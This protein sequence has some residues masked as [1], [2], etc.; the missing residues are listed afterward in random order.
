MDR[1]PALS[2]ATGA[3]IYVDEIRESFSLLDIVY[4]NQFDGV[5]ITE[6]T[7]EQTEENFYR[8]APPDWLNFHI[9]EVAKSNGAGSPFIKRDGY[10]RL[11]QQIRKRRRGPGTSAIKLYHHE[12]S[13]GTTLAMHVLWKLRKTFRC[14]VLTDSTPDIM[15]VTK[16][17]V[18]LFRAGNQDSLNTVL[19]LLDDTFNLDQ[20][21]DSIMEEIVEQEIDV[22]VPV[23]ILLSCVRTDH[24]ARETE[25]FCR[26]KEELKRN[27]RKDVIL[28]NNI[29]DTEKKL[30]DEK[31]EELSRKYGD[32]TKQFHGFNILQTNFSQDYIQEACAMFAK[33]GRKN[34]P[35]KTQL[36][37]FLSLLNAYV[38][39]SYLL[40]SHCLDFLIHDHPSHDEQLLL[41]QMQPFS[42]LI[43]TLQRGKRGQRK[44]RMAHPA[45]AKCCTE[46]LAEAGVCRSDTA[47]NFLSS[48][49]GDD[50]PACLFGFIKHM[51]TKREI[52]TNKGTE[53]AEV[54]DR[55]PR[56]ENDR[57]EKYSTL[58][59]HITQ[60]E[61]KRES[62]SVLKVASIQ[63]DEN[64]LFPQALAR[65]C[66][67]E[68]KD[69]QEAEIWAKR[70]KEREPKKSFIADTLG[71]VHKNHLKNRERPAEA[72]EILQLARKAIE[73]F[74]EEEQLAGKEHGKNIENGKTKSLHDFNIRGHFGFLQVC[75]ILFD[76]LVR[77]DEAWRGVLTSN[78]S[79]GSVLQTLGDNKLSRFNNLINSLREKVE[80]KFEFL[81]AFLT[82]SESAMK[83]DKAYVTKEAAECYKKYVGVSVP[84]H[85]G[86]LQQTLQ[87]LKQ[88][89]AVTSAGVLS[90]L[91]RRCTTSDVKD[92]AAWWE[93]ICHSEDFTTRAFVN[94]IFAKIMLK[95]ANQPLRSSDDQ[96]AF[97]QKKLSDMQAE[98]HMMALLLFWPTDDEGQPVSDLRQLIE[99][100]KHSY[101]QEYKTMFRWR[102][103]RPLFFIGPGKELRRFVH[104]RVLEI[105][106]TQ[107]ALQESNVY[108]RNESI[109]KDPTVQDHLLK[110]EGVVRNYRLYA[111]F[112]ST[113]IEVEAN[114]RDSLWKSGEVFF[115]LGFTINGPV[116][117]RIQ[118][119]LPIPEGPTGQLKLGERAIDS[120]HWTTLE[121]E[122]KTGDEVQ[123]YGLQSDA[124]R[125]ECSASALRWV[126]K[127]PVSLQYRFC[128]WEEHRGESACADYV[129][130]GPLLDISVAAGKLEEVYLPHWIDPE[131]TTPDMFVVLHVETCGDAVEQVS[132]VTPSH[133]KLL[134]PTFSPKGVMLRVRLGF[135]VKVYHDVMIFK[136]KQEFLTLH[137]H[138][139]PP[140]QDLQ[141]KVKRAES[142]HG[143]VLIPKPSP[144]KSLQMLDHFFL[145]SDTDTAEIQPESIKLIYERRT[146][147]EVFIRNADSDLRLKLKTGRRNGREEVV[148]TCTIRK[149]DYMTPSTDDEDQHFVDLNRTDLINGVKDTRYILDKLLE[150][151]LISNEAYDTVRGIDSERDQMREILT[152]VCSAG[153]EGK[154]EFHKVLKGIK[155]LRPLL[156]KLEK[157]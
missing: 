102:Y 149:G 73:A 115:Y 64:A 17:V 68:L 155:N 13:G 101:E 89:L 110:V 72:R 86:K 24:A 108:W 135:P 112:G 31:K 15:K 104:R 109:F 132:E 12:G 129:P 94:F 5:E 23:V 76:Q 9:S 25:L 137:V 69:Y 140:D 83:K 131:S 80:K 92:I 30:F 123:T 130:A 66:Y 71:Q 138:L 58:I 20:L 54:H 44:V 148:W 32:K 141:Q 99:N 154:D 113:E 133:V 79:A 116:A 121:P 67:G 35:L 120:S 11:V 21:Q 53:H 105:K 39:A 62:A 16:E 107:D 28:T 126:C 103:L 61:D 50:V 114:R 7:A 75:N 43:V 153:R 77:K 8:G 84:E 88:K 85:R 146:Y 124:G 63:F 26:E 40:E 33:I 100:V 136:T 98:D 38:P 151:G 10:D 82:Y 36:A 147:F 125:F 47:R 119:R 152:F 4:A 42:H 128:S 93:E 117:F 60:M 96:S 55:R 156:S 65:F 134:Q 59:L 150:L 19:L 106:W 14:A 90:C 97:R 45:I 78:V 27:E 127:E 34:K 122:V 3:L 29:S 56:E 143:S 91:D 157:C 1:G 52:K 57:L 87:K 48:F 46:L 37:A 139:V 111:S 144:G 49:C 74:E 95:N 142:P 41:D 6:E 70:A 145:S 22:D 81:D 118:R 2:S 18:H 51:L